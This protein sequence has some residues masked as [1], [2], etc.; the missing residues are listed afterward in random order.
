MRLATSPLGLG[1]ET[2][3]S[4]CFESMPFFFA[5][6]ECCRGLRRQHPSAAD[7]GDKPSSP[8]YNDDTPS[9]AVIRRRPPPL[10]ITHYARR[11][12]CASPTTRIHQLPCIR[13]TNHHCVHC[14]T[15]LRRSL[16]TTCQAHN[17]RS[18]ST[19]LSYI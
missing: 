18:I 3:R 8:L 14:P 12:P 13:I 6:G 11:L 16:T 10:L 2:V 17:R 15:T 7:N 4:L 19:S 5:E 9:I 1:D